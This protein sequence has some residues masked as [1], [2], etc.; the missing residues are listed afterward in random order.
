ME[1]RVGVLPTTFPAAC[2]PLCLPTM[3]GGVRPA[4]LP[5]LLPSPDT[6]I[7]EYV[8]STYITFNW[9]HYASF[10]PQVLFIINCF[11]K[12]KPGLFL[13][14]IIAFLS[15]LNIGPFTLGTHPWPPSFS[16]WPIAQA[17]CWG[18]PPVPSQC[19]PPL[20]T[21]SLGFLHLWA[22]L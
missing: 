3:V 17:P 4:V 15:L 6:L 20:H 1:S 10:V 12:N 22:V 5:H 13:T 21:R 14:I 16:S 19:L 8:S 7:C 2:R 9:W 18:P 11:K